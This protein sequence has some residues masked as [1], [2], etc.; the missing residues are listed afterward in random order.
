MNTRRHIITAAAAA[1]VIGLTAPLSAQETLQGEVTV[2]RSIEPVERDATPLALLPR[3]ELPRVSSPQ[4]DY[5][6]LGVRSRVIS[7]AGFAEPAMRPL[8]LLAQADRRGYVSLE[9]GAPLIDAS[10]SA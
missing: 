1:A 7:T 9:A 2:E 5:S 10:L 3:V 6:R 8:P 4:L